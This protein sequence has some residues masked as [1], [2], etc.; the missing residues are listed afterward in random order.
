[1]K[2]SRVF[3]WTWKIHVHMLTW[4]NPYCSVKFL[5]EQFWGRGIISL[6]NMW[7]LIVP[8]SL[9]IEPWGYLFLWEWRRKIWLCLGRLFFLR[10]ENQ[11]DEIQEMKGQGWANFSNKVV[12][13][14]VIYS[15]WHVVRILIWRRIVKFAI[16]IFIGILR[17][18]SY[19][20]MHIRQQQKKGFG[21][22]FGV[23]IERARLPLKLEDEYSPTREKWYILVDRV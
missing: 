3:L 23:P 5:R 11:F 16:H 20:L 22:L 8:Q 21:G 9:N 14:M 4:I 13:V 2:F 15:L 19:F 12:C 10:S 6:G 17:L 1:M 7:L 18:R